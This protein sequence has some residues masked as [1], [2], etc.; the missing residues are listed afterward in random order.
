VPYD[1]GFMVRGVFEKLVK[2]R[3]EI[4]VDTN[5]NK[6]HPAILNI[7]LL[8]WNSVEILMPLLSEIWHVGRRMNTIFP[9]CAHFLLR[10]QT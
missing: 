8:I 7:D 1:N 2:F 3:F 10:T 6:S 5:E 4:W 9:I